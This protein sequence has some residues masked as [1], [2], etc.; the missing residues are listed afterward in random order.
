MVLIAFDTAQ[1]ATQVAV[2]DAAG[3]VLGWA[4]EPM[5]TGHAERL[6]PM[7]QEVLA[8]AGAG[9]AD[10]SRIIVDVGPGTFTG[11]R[12]ALSAARTLGWSRSVP[13]IGVSSLEALAAEAGGLALA[14]VDARRDEL[15]AQTFEDGVAR[16]APEL[17]QVSVLSARENLPNRVVGSGAPLLAANVK[18][19]EVHHSRAWPD[20]VTLGLIGASREPT[21]APRPLYIR[22]PD[23]KPQAAIVA[24]KGVA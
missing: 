7:A 18:G 11:V 22:A 9:F 6:I 13:V 19:M 17:V 16:S 21:G 14:V 24:L 12:I 2:F 5:T 20:I 15:Y 4:S 23:A 8:K 10:L 3:S 1:D